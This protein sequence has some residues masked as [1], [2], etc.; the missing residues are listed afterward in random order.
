M[1]D[2]Y[3]YKIVVSNN[4]P[5]GKQDFKYFIGYKYSEKIILLCIFCP[6][7]I[8]HK[9]NFDENR[10]IYF[11]IKEEKDLIKYMEILEKVSNIIRNNIFFYKTVTRLTNL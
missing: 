4:F 1:N 6:Q 9:R 2:V 5:F 7:M 11:L 8:K 10:R 3:I